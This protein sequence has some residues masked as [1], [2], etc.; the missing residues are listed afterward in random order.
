VPL[1]VAPGELLPDPEPALPDR[2]PA[3]PNREA[4]LPDREP[5]LPDWNLFCPIL[6]GF[7]KHNYLVWS[8]LSILDTPLRDFSIG[9]QGSPH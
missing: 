3:L 4:I 5:V 9:S 8:I 1:L 6:A 2:E 7:V